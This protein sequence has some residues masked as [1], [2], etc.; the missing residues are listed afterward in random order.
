MTTGNIGKSKINEGFNQVAST[1]YAAVLAAGIKADCITREPHIT[2]VNYIEAGLDVQVEDG[3]YDF[4]FKNTMDSKL[5]IS[6]E[7]RNNRIIVR[8]IGR[9]QDIGAKYTLRADIAQRYYP[10]V[11]NVEN[12]ELKEGQKRMV[13]AGKEGLKV[14]VY[15]VAL[16]DNVKVGEELISTDIYQSI[17]SIVE[18][19]PN[20]KWNNETNK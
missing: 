6:S 19:G 8:I 14:N 12:V 11:I 15:R 17:K 13:S 2:Q 1:L 3:S 5:V 20:T 4:R 7:V 10:S 9:K 18:I 16:K